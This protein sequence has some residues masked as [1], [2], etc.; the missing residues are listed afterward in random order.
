MTDVLP[1]EED[2]DGGE[3]VVGGAANVL[4]DHKIEKIVSDR[5]EYFTD[6]HTHDVGEKEDDDKKRST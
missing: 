3:E 6:D 1:A 2:A 5:E 4:D